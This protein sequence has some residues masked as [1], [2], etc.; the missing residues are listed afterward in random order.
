[1]RAIIQDDLTENEIFK[2][3]MPF[4][5]YVGMYIHSSETETGYLVVGTTYDVDQR[6]LYVYVSSPVE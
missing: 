5:P 2:L 1:M 6:L 3:D 4:V